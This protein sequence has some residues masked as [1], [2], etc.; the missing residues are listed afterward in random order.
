MKKLKLKKVKIAQLSEDVLQN[1]KG[2]NEIIGDTRGG[3]GGTAETNNCTWTSYE[4]GTDYTTQ[5]GGGDTTGGTG[6]NCGTGTNTSG[7]ETN[8][9]CGSDP[10]NGGTSNCGPATT[11]APTA[12]CTGGHN[13]W[14]CT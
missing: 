4:C 13:G 9:N 10:C 1:L 6:D 11:G 7:C 8:I 14:Y 3:G 5:T 2:G 12:Q